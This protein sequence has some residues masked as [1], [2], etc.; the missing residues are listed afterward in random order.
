M[1]EEQLKAIA[2]QLRKPD[3]EFGKQLGVRMNDGNRY[4]NR[5][6]IA[7]LTPSAG[8]NILEI[9]M[10][11]GFFVNEIISG[12]PS[13]RYTGCDFSEAMVVEATRLNEDLVKKGRA[14]FIHAAADNIPFAAN[15][16]NK[17]FTVNTLYFW[18]DP[19]RTLNEIRRLLTLHGQLIIAIRPR[20]SMEQ[21]P[22]VKY[23]FTMFSK[24]EL[25]DLLSR[26]SFKVLNIGE[27]A[28]PEQEL[29]G[30]KISM[31]SLIVVAV[32]DEA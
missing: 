7:S 25:I 18:E 2:A 32:K 16:F 3:G 4:I 24:E 23:G 12:D 1:D 5:D 29:N 6:T 20:S 14:K 17:V 26:N 15:A 13:I 22:F 19:S 21:L 28:E 27:K 11:N 31:K 9:G 10:G 30:E 8:D